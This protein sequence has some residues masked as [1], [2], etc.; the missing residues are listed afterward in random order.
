V[1]IDLSALGRAN[2]ERRLSP[3]ACDLWA[4][5]PFADGSFDLVLAGEVLEHMP[6]P[7][8]L[9]EEISRVLTPDGVLVG[10]VPNAFRLK[11]RLRFLFGRP[12][13]DDP[14]HLRHFSPT[15]LE[16]LLGQ[17]FEEVTV[18]PCVGRLVRI[19]TRL[20]ANDLA[21]RVRRPHERVQGS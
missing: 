4:S 11:N 7:D 10:S 17:F 19:A 13:E 20:T 14:T 1:D 21:F 8:T 5:L 15:S 16:A 2:R 3:V 6:F 9:L 12:F 18:R